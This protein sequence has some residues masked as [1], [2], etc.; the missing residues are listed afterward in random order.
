MIGIDSKLQGM[1][2]KGVQNEC[3]GMPSLREPITH[4]R[5]GEWSEFLAERS[6]AADL[7]ESWAKPSG[8][9]RGNTRIGL[10]K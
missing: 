2:P 9:C 3:L 5:L 1:D 6:N 7:A 8:R 4:R 10:L